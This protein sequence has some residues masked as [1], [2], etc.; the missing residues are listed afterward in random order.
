M[1]WL[2]RKIE[3]P[4]FD[5]AEYGML[6]LDKNRNGFEWFGLVNM[7]IS[8]ASIELTIEV[9][10]QN[11]PSIEQIELIK[12]F[13]KRWQTTSHILFEHM[14]ECFRDS[15]WAKDK[16]EL[17]KMYFLS[18][19]DLKRDNSEWWIVMEPEFDVTSIFNFFPRF[20]L[21]NDEI[22]WSNLK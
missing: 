9:E 4:Q 15:K 16:N 12:E 18:A 7:P 17:Q 22:I 14:E 10:N 1:N 2:K 20:T 21:K 3:K 11:E 8:K 6:K 5:F 19:I 13:T